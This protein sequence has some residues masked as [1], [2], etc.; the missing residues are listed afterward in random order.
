MALIFLN[1]DNSPQPKRTGDRTIRFNSKTGNIVFSKAAVSEYDLKEGDRVLFAY[2]DKDTKKWY[3]LKT[4][5]ENGF[6][7]KLKN[8][9]MSLKNTPVSK[10]ILQVAKVTESAAFMVSKEIQEIGGNKLYEIITSSPLCI[11]MTRTVI[12]K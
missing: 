5:N 7:V 2:D 10:K 12:K 8:G 1:N 11:N 9:S 4:T 6:E 3:F